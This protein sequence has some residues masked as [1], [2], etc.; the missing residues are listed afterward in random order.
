MKLFSASICMLVAGVTCVTVLTGCG[1][2]NY[3]RKLF[4]NNAEPV[5]LEPRDNFIKG[6][7][8]QFQ[9]AVEAYGKAHNGKYPEK[10][11]DSFK[12][13]DYAGYSNVFSTDPKQGLIL[14]VNGARKDAES[15]RHGSREGLAPGVI[16]YTCVDGGKDYAIIGGAHDGL[17]LTDE[18]SSGGP[19]FV[20]SHENAPEY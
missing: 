2:D 1:T 20:L 13:P 3:A 18:Q 5:Q 9:R 17:M 8:L 19:H 15:L 7:M 14:P 4:K 11:D 10:I 16:E 6:N 12:S